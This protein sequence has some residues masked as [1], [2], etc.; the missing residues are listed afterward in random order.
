ML[1]LTLEQKRQRDDQLSRHEDIVEHRQKLLRL[2]VELEEKN[3]KW[4]LCQQRCDA[5]E[6]QML[7]WEQR[8]E[9]LNQK[10]RAAG[11]EVMQTRKV[12][13]KIQQEKREL[14][15]ERFL[16]LLL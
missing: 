15:K 2:T 9:Q 3:E 6:Q 8:K 4:L 10:W 14:I 16:I 12:L 5:M 13:E 7:S 1:A 11:E